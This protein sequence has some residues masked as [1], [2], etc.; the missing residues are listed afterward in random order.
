MLKCDFHMHTKEDPSDTWITYSAFD[1]IDY[2]AKLKFDVLA[3][4]H[5]RKFIFDEEWRAYAK[6]K[7]IL[8][9]PGVEASIEDKD[10]IVL[11]STKEVEKVKTFEEL[12]KFKKKHPEIFILAPHPFYP[13]RYCLQKKLF[14]HMDVFDGIEYCHYYNVAF[15]AYNKKAAKIADQYNKPLIGTS[16]AH[17]FIQFGN[18]YTLI[19]AEKNTLS[20]FTA[21]KERKVE[22]KTK[23]LSFLDSLRAIIP[24]ITKRIKG[25]LMGK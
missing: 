15:N 8:L 9:I 10:V 12:R 16:D 1:L 19:D 21:M 23:P 3:F 24:L 18:T 11:N 20:V 7:G 25:K 4:T 2:A 14:E 17:Q 5:H 13:R 22:V 6:K